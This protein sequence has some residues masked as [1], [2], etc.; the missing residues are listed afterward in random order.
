[1]EPIFDEDQDESQDTDDDAEVSSHNSGTH[2]TKKNPKK[3][4]IELT[5][6]I[7][8]RRVAVVTSLFVIV[9]LLGAAWKLGFL[10]QGFSWYNSASVTLT[11]LEKD[12][13]KPLSGVLVTL[14][15]VSATTDADGLAQLAKLT[16]GAVNVTLTKDGYT[17][18]NYPTYIY[19]GLNPLPD[20]IMEKAPDKVFDIKGTVTDVI[21]GAPITKVRVAVADKDTL[22]DASGAFT[23]KA[24][25]DVLQVHLNKDGFESQDVPLKFSGAAFEVVAGTL[26]PMQSVTFEQEKGG[27]T[28]LYQTDLSGLKI[29]AITNGQGTSSSS[30]AISSPD[31]THLA[32]L[33]DRD[34]ARIDDALVRKLYVEDQKGVVAKLSDDPNPRLVTWAGVSTI[35]YIYQNSASPAQDT[36]ISVNVDTKKRTVLLTPPAAATGIIVSIDALAVSADGKLIAYAE[37]AYNPNNLNDM[38]AAA[39]K[40]LFTIKLDGTGAKRIAS[41][42]DFVTNLYFSANDAKVRY[43]VSATQITAKEVDL[44]SGVETIAGPSIRERTYTEKLSFTAARL[45]TVQ[46]KAGRFAYID[47]KNG[48][49][50]IFVTALDGTIDKQITS[51]GTVNTIALSPNE[52]Y[53]L[54]TTNES[55]AYSLYVIGLDGGVPKKLADAANAHLQ[56]SPKLPV[57]P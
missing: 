6:R 51:L 42:S 55:G 13:H 52:S 16:S 32:F 14:Q 33:S 1:M 46:T 28:D 45:A 23:L 41:P 24:K 50:D 43:T 36:L 2:Q 44:A 15:G 29:A 27:K 37:N 8:R 34:G 26:M 31:Q 38:P 3:S 40:G 22:T 25:A 18:K 11:V 17:P 53:L 7:N 9:A 5:M 21:S 54:F 57:S 35:L 20:A 48:K 49:T 12:S 47:T 10:S 39:A 19:R 30:D 56:F 4:H